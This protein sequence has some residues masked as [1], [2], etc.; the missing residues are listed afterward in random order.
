MD[1]YLLVASIISLLLS[2]KHLTRDRKQ[3]LLPSLASDL[4]FYVKIQL[5]SF[6]YFVAVFYL[7]ATLVL[8]ACSLEM[9]SQMYAYGLLLFIALD[10][11]L[12]AIW[13]LYGKIMCSEKQSILF[14]FN[15]IGY[16][17]V[18]GCIVLWALRF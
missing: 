18:S 3:V 10:Y 8:F 12:F 5:S 2:I 4:G 17:L 1:S 14:Y 9:V 11:V 16:F 6:F 7:L 13:Q 15:W